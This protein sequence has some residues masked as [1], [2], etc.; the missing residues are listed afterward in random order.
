[1]NGSKFRAANQALMATTAFGLVLGL[2]TAAFAQ[3]S[4]A[5][6]QEAP[7]EEAQTDGI[8]DI[9]VTARRSSERAQ[10]VPIAITTITSKALTDLNVRDVMDM[11]KVT[12]GLFISSVQLSGKAR[13]AIR[14]QSENDD[15]LT[16]DRSVGVYIDGVS[17]EHD[18]GLTSAMIDLDQVEVLKGPQ[19][20]LFGKNTTGGAL[21]ITTNHPV[22]EWG[23]YADI[24]YGSYNRMQGLAVV[25]APIIQDK[26]AIRAVAQVSARDGYFRESNGLRAAEDNGLYGRLLIRA[27]PTDSIDILL[28]GDYIA[29]RNSLSHLALTSNSM[30]ASQNTAT[31]MLG[32]IARELGLNNA[33]ATDRLTA[34]NTWLTYYNASVANPRV[35]F[36]KVSDPNED[37]DNWSVSANIGVDL[38][39]VTARSIT[40]YRRLSRHADTD[41]DN[42]PFN[43]YEQ[44]QYAI[45]KNFTEEFR[46]TAI[47]GHGLDWQAGAFYNRETGQD[48]SITDQ[49]YLVN[50]NRS[51]IADTEIVSSSKAAYAQAV[52]NFGGFRVTG[53]IRY[54]SD[55][56]AVD[57]HNR[58]DLRV[59]QQ[60]LPAGGTSACALL[61]PAL[62]G[63][64]FP[65]CT[66]KASTKNSKA[67]WLLSADWHPMKSVMVYGSVS[68]GYRAGAFTTPGTSVIASV[69]ALNAAFTP[70]EP[71]SVTNYES[72]IKADLFDRHVRV[73][74]SGYYQKYSNIQVRVR[75]IV[76]GVLAQLTRNAAKATIYGGEAEVTIAPVRGLT[77]SGNAGY[78][79]ARYN[80]Y[81]ARDS[82]GNLVDFS[83]NPF[84]VP[85]WT[86]GL[87]GAYE[88]P[89]ADGSLRFNADYSW[90]STTVYTPGLAGVQVAGVTQPSYGLAGGRIAWHIDSQG[91]DI[92]VF[93]KN[94]FDKQYLSSSASLGPFTIGSVGEP[95]T[96]GVQV[97]K[98]F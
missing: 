26:L 57:S 89:L 12:P 17:F 52:Y 6:Q 3:D 76:N 38:G 68:T 53:G 55:Y 11:Q 95:R 69:A 73:N 70:Y 33:S 48:V 41:Y 7:A 62:G 27:N 82:A 50:A 23:G 40:S 42:T 47:D 22:Y 15:R 71:E 67:T 78:V 92:A 35:G 19:G 61:T 31:G 8:Q 37:L 96:L 97:R 13:I 75:D 86:Y 2:P 74:V 1:M 49:N 34:Y 88:L 60:P 54:T 83:A 4:A 51:A 44:R 24:L 18:Y 64:V 65:N 72:G 32:E 63:P 93:A 58:I 5:K 59:A 94:V 16:G 98:T 46:L 79:H 90:R 21:N 29:L 45:S 10:D 56:R 30:L 66:Y 39:G 36:A 85:E 25:N 81:I 43:L 20:T 77:F 80:E 28:S 14:G 84:P 91:L 87:T 9:V